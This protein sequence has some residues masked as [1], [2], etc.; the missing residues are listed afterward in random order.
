MAPLSS[1]IKYPACFD[2]RGLSSNSNL[3]GEEVLIAILDEL[4][5]FADLVESL[6][7]RSKSN[8]TL[9]ETRKRRLC[10]AIV[11]GANELTTQFNAAAAATKDERPSHDT[12][13]DLYMSEAPPKLTRYRNKIVAD[14]RNPLQEL[15]DGKSSSRRSVDLESYEIALDNILD[16]IKSQLSSWLAKYMGNEAAERRRHTAEGS[17]GN[18]R[19]NQDRPHAMDPPRYEP[20]KRSREHR[21]PGGHRSSFWC[22]VM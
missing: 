17:R 15:A 13:I 9:D 7:A 6:G 19:G 18:T 2:T 20:H 21:R 4:G 22:L 11:K 16:G 3:T 8:V 1:K 12:Q 14:L 5:R 10:D